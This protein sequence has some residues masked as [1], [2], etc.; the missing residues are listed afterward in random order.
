MADLFHEHH[1]STRHALRCA[2]GGS[3]L[4]AV[5]LT[6]R[7]TSGCLSVVLFAIA[8]IAG[9]PQNY[10]G[11]QLRSASLTFMGAIIGLLSYAIVVLVSASSRAAT[12]FVALPFIALFS[13]L[14]PAAYLMPLPPVATIT[15]GLNLISRFETKCVQ[16]Y[17]GRACL[18]ESVLR[19]FADAAFAWVVTNIVNL[20]FPDRAA[21]IGR[22]ILS[23]QLRKIGS[24]VSSVASSTF[25]PHVITTLQSQESLNA[26]KNGQRPSVQNA[27]IESQSHVNKPGLPKAS[28]AVTLSSPLKRSSSYEQLCSLNNYMNRHCIEETNEMVRAAYTS[29]TFLRG[30]P[31]IGSTRVDDYSTIAQARSFLQAAEYEPQLLPESNPRWRNY[32]AWPQVANSIATLVNKVSCLE[33]VLELFQSRESF[34][35]Y[36]RFAKFVGHAYAPLWVSHYATCAASC[37]TLSDM[38]LF[39]TCE[40]LK[41]DASSTR[42]KSQVDVKK[43]RAR[44]AEMY[45]GF[46][47]HRRL[48]ARL[49]GQDGAFFRPQEIRNLETRN[50][51]FL[52][53]QYNVSVPPKRRAKVASSFKQSQQIDERRALA[54]FAIE[55]HALA[56]ELGHLRSAMAQLAG[57][58]NTRGWTEPL[59][60]LFKSF[61]LLKNRLVEVFRWRLHDWEVHF[62]FTHGLMLTCI[63]GIAL[64]VSME[65]P[66]FGRTEMGWAF[67]SAL[68]SAQLSVEP[69]ILVCFWRVIGTLTG[70]GLGFGFGTILRQIPTPHCQSAH[71]WIIPFMFI[72]IFFSL[73]S[74]SR[75]YRY[76][77]F[78]VIVTTAIMLLCPRSGPGCATVYNQ[79]CLNCYP[80]WKYMVARAINVSLGILFAFV[81]HVLFWPRFANEVALNKLS[82]AFQNAPR[83]MRRLRLKFFS[84][85]L[86]TDFDSD[87]EKHVLSGGIHKTRFL[88]SNQVEGKSK[89]EDVDIFINNSTLTQ[90]VN[91]NVEKYVSSAIMTMNME[92]G[93]FQKGPFRLRPLLP[94]LKSDFIALTVT[95][96]ELA[97][98][99]GRRPIFSPSYSRVA[100]DELIQPML[101]QYETIH[102]S[103]NNLVGV[104]ST[105]IERDRHHKVD[106]T[107]ELAA[108]LGQAVAHLARCRSE[109]RLGAHSR[110]HRLFQLCELDVNVRQRLSSWLQAGDDV[111][112]QSRKRL[113]TVDDS[114]SKTK[115]QLH[116]D[117]IILFDAF[118]FVAEGCLSAFVRIAMT[119]LEEAE[120]ELPNE[121]SDAE[122]KK[123]FLH[124]KEKT[125]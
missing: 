31:P 50:A 113:Q 1:L 101:R 18:A 89:S 86:K 74:T 72:V 35:D 71:L 91:D 80:G 53:L 119:V 36:E 103:L 96:S 67:T 33:S 21:N 93:V 16:D 49:N 70:A 11:F 73:A 81:F 2:V 55:S 26:S 82:R 39:S 109:L 65:S 38:L 29:L 95:L 99:L 87:T 6:A 3:V 46:L 108:D 52:D 12:F 57:K 10:Q 40:H 100:F 48:V 28:V 62:A 110:A 111:Q 105:I 98:I 64:F 84:S 17:G 9:T 34:L 114:S 104:A 14:R 116:V 13:T 59:H 118:T 77:V 120:K 88:V 122:S 51:Q 69:T 97:R 68:L 56:E 79:T 42:I 63:L 7:F 76:P 24:V 112:E 41:S 102:I 85:G 25:S 61:P 54:F 106:Q 32:A 78:L 47:L 30:L 66:F 83:V 107:R 8:T 123:I 45:F 15:L 90:L 22:R 117:D 27:T 121:E 124:R 19:I 5:G 43:W 125:S 37:A 4:T 20:V 115:S 75:T 92:A 60:F 23:T 58:R 44:R 94:K